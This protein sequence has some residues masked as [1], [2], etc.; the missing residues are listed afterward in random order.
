[1]ATILALTDCV[2]SLLERCGPLFERIQSEN[3]QLVV[4]GPQSER[5]PSPQ[6]YR[7]REVPVNF[8]FDEPRRMIWLNAMLQGI[9]D[10]V[11]PDL[12]IGDG[13]D[14]VAWGLVSS[15][16]AQYSVSYVMVHNANTASRA[17]HEVHD[18]LTQ[19]VASLLYRL[20]DSD[21]HGLCL[22]NDS[23]YRR[24]ARRLVGDADG[25]AALDPSAVRLQ[26]Y[27]CRKLPPK[28]SFLF[29][30][31]LVRPAGVIEYARAARRIRA[32][33]PSVDFMLAGWPE[34]GRDGVDPHR[35]SSWIEQGVVQYLGH[36]DDVRDAMG[37]AAVFVAPSH[38]PR[39]C[40]TELKAM[41][42]G[43]PLVA[44]RFG[45]H[46]CTVHHSENG[47]VVHPGCVDSLEWAMR[48]FIGQ[49]QLRETM[50][51]NSRKR[52]VTEFAASLVTDRLL[53]LMELPKS[54]VQPPP[55]PT[56]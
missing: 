4:V 52:A 12:F 8:G 32:Q 34:S 48:H 29:C 24:C 27:R 14:A 54:S 47:Y 5:N 10:E 46:R 23:A 25:I 38:R 53:E 45:S 28:T 11:E 51:A 42:M 18:Y 30:A 16:S 20:G 44:T 39:I 31:P 41:A 26:R 40:P 3:H 2:Q 49:P 36:L 9:F 55:L 6:G 33:Y 35:I 21:D 37:Q 43:R 50:G 7:H 13:P 1:M 56:G 17:L 22:D 15:W 19:S